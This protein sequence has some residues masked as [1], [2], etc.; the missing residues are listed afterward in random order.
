MSN[1]GFFIISDIS[2]YTKFMTE[3][4]LEHAKG[5]LDALFKVQLEAVSPPLEVSNFQG[6]AILFYALEENVLSGQSL[7]QMI[8]NIYFDFAHHIENMQL[9]TTCV[10]KACANIHTLD[11]KFFIHFGEFVF[12]E[13]GDRKE[14][15]GP[16]VILAHRL[17][18]NS[19]VEATNIT[20]YALF[21]EAA[22]NKIELKDICEHEVKFHTEEYEHLGEVRTYVHCLH[23]AWELEKERDHRKILVDPEKAW[24]QFERDIPALPADIWDHATQPKFKKEWAHLSSIVRVDKVG[25]RAG[26]ATKYH[27][28]H[29]MGNF[30]YEVVDWRPFDYWTVSGVV[31]PL[32]FRYLQTERIVPTESG[33]K[34][35]VYLQPH[36]PGIIGNF[37]NGIKAIIVKSA[38]QKE[39]EG[40]RD[41][42]KQMILKQ[43]G[44][45]SA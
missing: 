32:K 1:L 36:A 9:N 41:R 23:T 12:Q 42:M 8:D 7:L 33:C 16:D 38:L 34:F 24:V 3:S 37:L 25:K 5:I 13:I 44:L 21:T 26:N 27:C 45:S 17:M 20:A 15:S 35:I 43:K 14:L 30:D 31:G 18:K 6:D 4:E 19:V 10:C 22:A 2:G 28:V 11:L 39:F 29:E 40:G